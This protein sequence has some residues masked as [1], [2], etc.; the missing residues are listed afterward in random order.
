MKKALICIFGE[1]YI[2]QQFTL[3]AHSKEIEYNQLRRHD[4]S[5]CHFLGLGHFFVI[6][7][8]LYHIIAH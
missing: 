6:L 2:S 1:I 3:K 7:S 5:V 4:V 8:H